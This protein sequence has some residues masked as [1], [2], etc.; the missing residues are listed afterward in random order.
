MR[1]E[2]GGELAERT[3]ANPIA[4]IASL[5]SM[6]AITISVLARGLSP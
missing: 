3:L 6:L 1:H 2:A 4:V 5:A